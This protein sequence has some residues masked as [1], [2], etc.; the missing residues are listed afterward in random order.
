MS[1]F[2][3]VDEASLLS[4][5]IRQIRLNFFCKVIKKIKNIYDYFKGHSSA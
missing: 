5:M 4:W 3:V 2:Y 1:L